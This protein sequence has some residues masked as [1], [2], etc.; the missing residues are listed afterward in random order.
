[1]KRQ[2]AEAKKQ[3]VPVDAA[4]VSRGDAMPVG[5]NAGTT[6]YTPLSVF[7]DKLSDGS[8]GPEM[9]VIPEGEFDMGSNDFDDEKPIHKVRVNKPFALGKTEVTQTQ[10]RQVMDKDPPTPKDLFKDCG[11]CPV[12]RV[13]WDDAQEFIKKLNVMTGKQYRLP[14]EAEWEYA[15]K[16]GGNSK[17]AGSDDI[18]SVAWYGK[19]SDRKT[20]AVAQRKANAWGLYD[21]SG[22]VWEWVEDSYHDS[23]VGAPDDGAAW[24]S[25][26]NSWEKK[27]KKGGSRYSPPHIPRVAYRGWHVTSM[28]DDIDGFRLARMLTWHDLLPPAKKLP[29]EIPIVTLPQRTG[30]ANP[31]GR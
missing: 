3:A 27:V 5:L 19:N 28:Y 21:M 15:A 6:N 22:N 1:M 8:L 4:K 14:S 17:Y 13:S 7:R 31:S 18:D 23:Y 9:V 11:D 20:H 30:T 16:A 24:K 25:G 12:E 2:L 10:W 29:F 26:S